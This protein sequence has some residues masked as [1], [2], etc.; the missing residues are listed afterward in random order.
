[1]SFVLRTERAGAVLIAQL[2]GDLD[3]GADETLAEL[4]KAVE[5]VGGVVLDFGRIAYI[6]SS[7]LALLVRLVRASRLAGTR[8]SA[9]GLSDH[10]R[11]IFDITQLDSMILVRNDIRSAEAAVTEGGRT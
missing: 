8:V 3:R 1:M 7:G 5:T 4:D 10:Y 11:H 9:V 6:S 2:V